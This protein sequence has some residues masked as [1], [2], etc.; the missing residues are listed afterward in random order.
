MPGVIRRL[1]PRLLLGLLVALAATACGLYAP[2]LPRDA[3]EARYAAPP[4]RFL[5]VEGLRLHLRDTGPP[6]APPVILLHGFAS[7][8]HTWDAWAGLLEADHRVIRL[9]LPGFGLTGADPTGDYSD[10][11]A[12]AVLAATMDAL[13]VGRADVIGSSMGGRIAWAFAAARPE[14]VERLV[15]MAPDGFAGPGREYGVRGRVPLLLCALP[16]TLPDFLLRRSLEPAYGRR[17]ALDEATLARTRAML[18]APGVRRAILDR[19][20]GAV[21]EPPEPILARIRAPVLLL[22]GEADRLIPAAHAADYRRALPGARLVVLPGL[23]HVPM[24]EDPA[25][26]LEPVRAFLAR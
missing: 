16:Y 4:S 22:W 9:D 12:V 26:A 1:A 24:E 17:E 2:D 15:L 20:E 18:L 21:L 10:A 3:L 19:A 5:P 13:G 7:S 11:R 8:L 23:G 14:R 6:G 25:G